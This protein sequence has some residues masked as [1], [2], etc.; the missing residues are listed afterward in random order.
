[1]WRKAKLGK[2]GKEV[3]ADREMEELLGAPSRMGCSGGTVR[4]DPETSRM[5]CEF[6]VT[7][8]EERLGL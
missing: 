6:S 5:E 2:L 7:C 3:W 4:P 8:R 1:M